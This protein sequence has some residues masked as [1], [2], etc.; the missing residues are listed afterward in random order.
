MTDTRQ[1]NIEESIATER[2]RDEACA[3]RDRWIRL[4]NRLE[5]AVTHHK[6]DTAGFASNADDSLYAA[7]DR[8]LRD[9]AVSHPVSDSE[10]AVAEAAGPEPDFPTLSP[11]QVAADERARRDTLGANSKPD[12]TTSKDLEL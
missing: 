7:R 8:I 5:A 2:G 6:R 3:E 10:Q 12:P 9:A 4:F 1:S 11:E